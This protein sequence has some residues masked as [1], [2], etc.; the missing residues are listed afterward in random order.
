MGKSVVEGCCREVPG[1]VVRKCWKECC[2]D[3]CGRAL[4]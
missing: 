3:V 4:L 1:S 2:K